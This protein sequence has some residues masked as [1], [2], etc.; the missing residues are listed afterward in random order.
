L[1]VPLP[2]RPTGVRAQRE[3]KGRRI[4][5]NAAVDCD[6]NPVT[7]YNV[8]WAASAAG[9]FSQINTEL[10]TDT[11]YFDASSS[12]G[13]NAGGGGGSGYYVVSAVDSAGDESAMSLAVKP[14]A[15]LASSAAE[16]VVPGCFISTV[17]GK[18]PAKSAWV[19]VVS[20]V[21]L[22][23]WRKA[24][25]SRHKAKGARLRAHS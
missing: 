2:Y 20:M 12:M 4:Q 16:S 19:V 8:Y 24:K 21:A 9:P 15:A 6:G 10:V 5:W 13:V 14:A 1:K 17:Q 11:T 3:T 23:I 18:L 25:G 7:G 22:F